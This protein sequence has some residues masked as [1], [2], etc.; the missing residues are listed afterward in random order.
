MSAPH[1]PWAAASGL[2][3]TTPRPG[4]APDVPPSLTGGPSARAESAS[5]PADGPDGG[6]AGVEARAGVGLR[7][8]TPVPS[9]Q[10]PPTV[11]PGPTSGARFDARRGRDQSVEEQLCRLES[12]MLAEAGGDPA[13]REAV[14]RHL[15]VATAR[16]DDATIR[17][18]LPVLIEREVRRRLA[19]R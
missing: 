13:V 17:Q 6:G 5:T 1:L 19:G 11:A 14:R 9:K 18:F 16:F 10:S 4:V 8:G 12:R 15:T 3:D 7:L 2:R